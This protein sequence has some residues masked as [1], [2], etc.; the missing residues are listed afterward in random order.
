MSV[1]IFFLLLALG[2]GPIRGLY[3]GNLTTHHFHKPSCPYAPSPGSS[4]FIYL[5]L[6][7]RAIE[8]GYSPCLRCLPKY[9]KGVSA[10]IVNRTNKADKK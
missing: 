8:A 1:P 10:R 7:C 5:P 6:R 9:V 4:N 3:F 2:L